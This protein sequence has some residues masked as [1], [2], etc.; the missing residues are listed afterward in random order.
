MK[1][2]VLLLLLLLIIPL[3][4][5]YIDHEDSYP[6]IVYNNC[7]FDCGSRDD[8]YIWVD[9]F[10][11]YWWVG[12]PTYLD[13]ICVDV[14][15]DGDLESCIYFDSDKMDECIA[16]YVEVDDVVSSRNFDVGGSDLNNHGWGVADC[17]VDIMNVSLGAP[18]IISPDP[19]FV[20]LVDSSNQRTDLDLQFYMY[21][22]CDDSEGER[23]INNRNR[24]A[25]IF[26]KKGSVCYNDRARVSGLNGDSNILHDYNECVYIDDYSGEDISYCDPDHMYN[27]TEKNKYMFSDPDPDLYYCSFN[28][29]VRDDYIVGKKFNCY[30]G[31]F[32]PNL[33][34]TSVDYGGWC[35]NCSPDFADD[36]SFDL[37]FVAFDAENGKRNFNNPFD[38]S[39][40]ETGEALAIVPV[41]IFLSASALFLVLLFIAGLVFILYLFGMILLVRGIKEIGANIIKKRNKKS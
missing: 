16:E 39:Y 2:K 7:S 41:I 10:S 13:V 14:L 12:T 5:S 31:V 17:A 20:G 19:D 30:N 25:Q 11:C 40:C 35:G 3:V 37:A 27:T 9:D 26:N 15:D 28:W 8:E 29:S 34:E 24:Q 1:K 22:D 23:D 6:S 4:S 32:D 18:F 36:I 33:N 21:Y 38:P